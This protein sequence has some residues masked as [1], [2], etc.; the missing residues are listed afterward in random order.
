MGRFAAQKIMER[1]SKTVNGQRKGRERKEGTHVLKETIGQSR[2]TKDRIA[3]VA[4]GGD[5][6][7]T[8]EYPSPQKCAFPW[9]TWT[10]I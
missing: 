4:C 6:A 8:M 9:G 3:A 1:G 7:Y 5:A 10:P 2:L